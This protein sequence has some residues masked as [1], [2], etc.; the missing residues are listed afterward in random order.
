MYYGIDEGHNAYPDTGASG[1]MQEDTGTHRIGDL[2]IA[3]LISAGNKALCVT[4]LGQKFN[5]VVA[6]L[7]K[8]CKNANDAKVDFYVAIHMNAS[9]GQG[10]GT[11]VYAMPGNSATNAISKR[12]CDDICLAIGTSNRG[13]KDGGDLFVLRNT[14][15]P[16]ILVEVCFCDSSV[17]QR[18]Y[19]EQAI[20]NA[21]VKGLTGQL[22]NVIPLP[23]PSPVAKPAVIVYNSSTASMQITMN[24]LFITD[25][26]GCRLVED[27]IAGMRTTQAVIKFQGIMGLTKDGIAG[28][29]TL[30]AITQILS[31]PMDS[32]S[33]A[34]YEYATRYIQWRIGTGVDGSFAYG[35]ANALKIWQT[36]HHLS[37]D[38]IAGN[39]TWKILIG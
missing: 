26:S 38:G 28:A 16:A 20:A 29:N 1:W 15:A 2:V 8:R 11:E 31:K 10:H 9:D 4:P 23:A 33:A 6:S 35:T 32:Y 17:D 25:G 13:V 34:H 36:N 18:L 19:N 24:K 37:P 12:V 39:A 3:G 27:G 21:I 30:S 22:S 5:S 14:N 7:G